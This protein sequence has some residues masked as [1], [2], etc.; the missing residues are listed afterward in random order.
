MINRRCVYETPA[1]ML[2]IDEDPETMLRTYQRQ[3]VRLLGREQG[4]GEYASPLRRRR[5]GDTLVLHV[6]A[7]GNDSG[8]ALRAFVRDGHPTWAL[9]ETC[10]R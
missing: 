2:R 4:R 8:Y 5:V 6:S 9:L 3:F 10:P 7:D 1:V